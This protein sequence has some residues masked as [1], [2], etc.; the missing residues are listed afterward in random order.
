MITPQA[1]LKENKK[2]G[3][4]TGDKYKRQLNEYKNIS[5]GGMLYLHIERKNADEANTENFQVI[6]KDAEGNEIQKKQMRTQDGKMKKDGSGYRNS[7]TVFIK[8]EITSD[9]FVEVVEGDT[10]YKFKVTVPV[11]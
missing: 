5:I 7:G 8:T 9:F 6:I 2:K 3:K 4:V 10:V 1:R 11:S